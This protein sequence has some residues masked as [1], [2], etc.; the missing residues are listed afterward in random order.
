MAVAEWVDR[1]LYPFEPNWFEVD[2]KTLHYVD[3]G[4]GD[5]V[6]FVHGLPTWS[7][8]Y[9]DMIQGLKLNYRCIAVDNMGFGLSQKPSSCTYR[10]EKMAE[11]LSELI[12]K[13]DLQNITFVVNGM[14][15]PI[16]LSYALDHPHNVK[17][18][19]LLN[20]YM[21]P[22]KGN[23]HA[24]KIARMADSAFYR[25]LQLKYNFGVET[26]FKSNLKDRTHYSKKIH[27]HYTGPFPSPETRH[28]PLDYARALNTS[29][30]WLQNLW[31]RRDELKRIPALLLWGLLDPAFG[32]DAL[33][34][35][36][37]EVWPEA[38]VIRFK[39]NGHY[40]AE[41]QGAGLVPE[42][43]M[44]LNDSAYLPTTTVDA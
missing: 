9:R 41:E 35:W 14:G 21:W 18:L 4:Q 6:V 15:G 44:F 32:E 3:V 17:H 8:M 30:P 10:P 19:I 20:T 23:P 34:R 2:H 37:L 11:Y 29:G 38:K 22:L 16:G 43:A 1:T 5:P 33:K 12:R 26:I 28:A 39:T 40:L 31:E 13:L 36:T 7:F 24:E 27:D 25:W 42:M